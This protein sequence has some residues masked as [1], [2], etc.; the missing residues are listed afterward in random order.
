MTGYL[1]T[2]VT[3]PG[4]PGPQ[5]LRYTGLIRR[6]PLRFL[7][8]MRDR[9]G[10]VLQFPIP[11]PATYLVASAEGTQQVLV[12][13]PGHYDKDTIQYR[14][15]SLVTGPGLLAARENE[16]REQRPVVQPAFHHSFLP[17]VAAVVAEETAGLVRRWRRAG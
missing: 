16:W 11:R 5:M 1:G 6:D 15:L 4:P 8:M 12:G 2:P 14:S 17:A 7:A 3:A 13:R 9:Y 10:D